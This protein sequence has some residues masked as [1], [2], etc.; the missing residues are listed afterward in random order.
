MATVPPFIDNK[1][2]I[3]V[4]AKPVSPL[5]NECLIFPALP[6]IIISFVSIHRYGSKK[7][8]PIPIPP[9]SPPE[10]LKAKACMNFLPDRSKINKTAVN[11]KSIMKSWG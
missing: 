11:I 2:N 3:P 6:A 4:A 9:V 5:S 7:K 8:K 10:N 1:T